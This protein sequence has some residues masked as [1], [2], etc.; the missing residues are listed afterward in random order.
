M[1]PSSILA[2]RTEDL[3]MNV[4]SVGDFYRNKSVFVTGASGFLGKVLIHKL[5]TSC[6]GVSNIFVLIRE[7]KGVLPEDRLVKLLDAPIF[8]SVPK[9]QTQKVQV[10]GGDILQPHLGLSAHD[11]RRLAD[12]VS[13][14]FH[15]AATV[16]FDEEMTLS[17]GMNVLGT[18]RMLDL[19]K[20][21]RQLSAFVHVSTAYAH[22]DKKVIEERFMLEDRI[23]VEGIVEDCERRRLA[24]EP[25][26]AEE[27]REMIG[28]R[29]NTYT[30][31]KAMAEQVVSDET[32]RL[33]IVVVRPSIVVASLK[34]P[35]P[36]W[37]D[38]FNGPTGKK[39]NAL[40]FFRSL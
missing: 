4:G 37:I 28:A 20:R 27:T 40:Q 36:G 17:V 18:K 26:T 5:L 12:E 16:K 14:V 25:F 32:G 21:M 39:G 7:K 9:S 35:I 34:E 23:D 38:N 31:T 10:V 11:E 3:L 24:N 13:V 30:F 15:S 8:E 22:C 33:P 29:P 19:A 2:D 6:P 1:A